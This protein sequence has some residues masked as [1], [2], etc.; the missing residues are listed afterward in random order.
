MRVC[1]RDAK[2]QDRERWTKKKR[3]KNRSETMKKRK[4]KRMVRI[5][6]EQ[7]REEEKEKSRGK[8]RE[9]EGRKSTKWNLTKMS[10][11]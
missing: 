10:Q 11:K 6:E 9:C 2:L 7:K 5:G 3:K 1:V 4:K 8:L